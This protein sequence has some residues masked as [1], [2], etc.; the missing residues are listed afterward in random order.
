M[1]ATFICENPETLLYES[2]IESVATCC[3]YERRKS[4]D[5]PVKGCFAALP[6]VGSSGFS[7]FSRST[8]D[9]AGA[10]SA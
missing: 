10:R 6:C 4:N 2:A 3:C 1:P 7:G 9:D 5:C 8:E